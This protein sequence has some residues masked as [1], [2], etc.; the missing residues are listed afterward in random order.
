MRER[1]AGGE[2]NLRASTLP[3][4]H[5]LP[6]SRPSPR[7]YPSPCA[8]S[9]TA[10]ME[11]VHTFTVRGEGHTLGTL[12]C[13]VGATGPAAGEDIFT[14]LVSHPQSSDVQF[15][16]GAHS[17]AAAAM[18]LDLSAALVQQQLEGLMVDLQLQ[19]Q[20]GCAG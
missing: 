5:S 7:I 4:S 12:I 11:G 2:S 19:A 9:A 13:A 17:P 3:L 6:L 16:V 14:Y 20:A 10:E 1:G 8:Q 18:L 15:R